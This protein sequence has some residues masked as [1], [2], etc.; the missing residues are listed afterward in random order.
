MATLHYSKAQSVSKH[1][2]LHSY[3]FSLTASTSAG[4]LQHWK[5]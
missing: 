1:L 3:S 4:R 5:N 2:S